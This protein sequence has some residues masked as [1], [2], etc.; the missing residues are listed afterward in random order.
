MLIKKIDLRARD[1]LET[2][3]F[4]SERFLAERAVSI[5]DTLVYMET[6]KI[7]LGVQPCYFLSMFWPIESLR[8]YM[9][10]SY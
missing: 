8:S 3:G 10:C 1:G 4:Q 9:F 5:N 6:S 2:M 7:Y